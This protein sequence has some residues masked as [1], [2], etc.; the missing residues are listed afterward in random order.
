MLQRIRRYGTLHAFSNRALKLIYIIKPRTQEIE[1]FLGALDDVK[2]HAFES[3]TRYKYDP[4]DPH[5]IV[6]AMKMAQEVAPTPAFPLVSRM[7]IEMST[8]IY[9]SRCLLTD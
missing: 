9:R 1:Y 2:T 5:K 8:Q 3:P 6:G 4:S 7:F